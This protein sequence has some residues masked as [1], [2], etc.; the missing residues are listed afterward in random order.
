MF[1]LASGAKIRKPVYTGIRVSLHV[2][3]FWVLRVSARVW[4]RAKRGPGSGQKTKYPHQNP[5]KTMCF[6][7]FSA[8]QLKTFKSWPEPCGATEPS[9]GRP[10]GRKKNTLARIRSK[11]CVFDTF[12]LY[13][14]KLSNPGLSHMA[15]LSQAGAG[16]RAE[17]KIRSPESAQNHVFL[18]LFGCTTQNFQILSILFFLAC[19]AR[20]CHC[21]AGGCHC[22]CCRAC[23]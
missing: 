22:V 5:L 1:P 2:G 13:N 19:G 3:A 23:G 18:V 11:P 12:R 7:Y 6:W 20:C 16:Q 15:P 10:A 4:H 21:G 14:S 9:G 8:V 17:N